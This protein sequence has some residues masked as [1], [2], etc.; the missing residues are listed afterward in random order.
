MKIIN[1]HNEVD[2]DWG[3]R[4]YITRLSN[5]IRAADE[6]IL[7]SINTPGGAVFDGYNL[8]SALD[9]AKGKTIARAEGLAASFGAYVL[10]YADEAE[11]REHSRIMIHKAYARYLPEDEQKRNE[12]IN[13]INIMNDKMV[14]VFKDKGMKP[15]LVDEIFSPDS[16]KNYWF[17]ANEALEVGLID[18]I[19]PSGKEARN[20]AANIDE[21]QN[22]TNKFGFWQENN[23][24]Y[25]EIKGEHKM[26]GKTDEKLTA[27]LQEIKNNMNEVLGMKA[28]L[29]E[30]LAK[31]EAE[32]AEINAK[33]ENTG[34]TIAE[35]QKGIDEL[36]A[37][38]TELKSKIEAQDKLYN[39]LVKG[40]EAT[41]SDFEPPVI[42]ESTSAVIE[43][44]P[45]AS[46]VRKEITKE[47]NNRKKE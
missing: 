30:A 10:A 31:G 39:A 22:L 6:D 27:D 41:A 44:A 19:I 23:I 3:E 21:I 17:S 43:K 1:L 35:L 29:E 42:D 4:E 9:D 47:I 5:E 45:S 37:E 20:I 24:N 25:S 26:F 33:F 36:K 32:L 7:L 12:I 16:N 40:I 8:L 15:E 28:S 38:N 13:E 18:R 14:K 46:Q 2:N 11:A 34:D